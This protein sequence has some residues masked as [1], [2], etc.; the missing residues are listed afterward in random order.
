M[1]IRVVDFV[2]LWRLG[3]VWGFLAFAVVAWAGVYELFGE[4]G[5]GLATFRRMTKCVFF[6]LAGAGLAGG[7]GGLR[8]VGFC[9]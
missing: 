4:G 3:D 6:G 7:F 8:S 1:G 5:G 9:A 2:A